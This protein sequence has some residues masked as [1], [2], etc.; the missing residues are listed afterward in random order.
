[1]RPVLAVLRELL[2][3]SRSGGL[4]SLAILAVVGA[5]FAFLVTDN[6][7]GM[8]LLGIVM[9][10]LMILET[11][12][13][14]REYRKLR[15][16]RTVVL[17]TNGREAVAILV[18]ETVAFRYDR[19]VL[20]QPGSDP[21][22]SPDQAHFQ[23]HVMDERHVVILSPVIPPPPARPKRKDRKAVEEAYQHARKR[24]GWLPQPSYA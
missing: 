18:G 1:M 2:F 14:A 15:D 20:P 13:R 3:P 9:V 8:S 6:V 24:F 4:L 17:I 19:D 10:A 7:T 21:A 23:V 11:R 16:M 5:W 22:F 12:L